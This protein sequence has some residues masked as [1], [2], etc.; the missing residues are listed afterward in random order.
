MSEIY[1]NGQ[2]F[3]TNP[4]L[5]LED[6]EFKFSNLYEYL[7]M[8]ELKDETIKILDV[9]GGAGVLGK[10]VAD[11]FFKKAIKVNFTAL[12][13]SEKMLSEQKNNNPHITNA[14]NISISDI[15]N[16]Y[17]DLVLMIDV[18]EHV[19]NYESV[20]KKLSEI[21]NNIIYNI[22]IEINLFDIL[23]NIK[24]RGGY[25]KSQEKLIGHIN[26]FS[27]DSSIRFIEKYY[28]IVA[29]KF[30]GYY[31]HI[32]KS[33]NKNYKQLLSSKQ[34]RYEVCI[35]KFIGENIPIIASYII[36]GSNYILT[37]RK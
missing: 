12:D 18:I 35:S 26:R 24:M 15:P 37:K 34:R 16:N 33:E 30:V 1:N 28:D 10:F 9:G 5:H 11:Y 21:S 17:Y 23:R 22:P 7:N 19:E 27:Y 8:V 14:L 31:K 25:Y 3:K 2:Y 29:I 20:A 32:L 6:T 4:N 13:L 36:Q